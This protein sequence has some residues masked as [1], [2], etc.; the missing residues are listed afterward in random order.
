MGPDI[1][2]ERAQAVRAAFQA[3]VQDPAFVADAEKLNLAVTPASGEELAAII[4]DTFK[5]TPEEI[6]VARKYHH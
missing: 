6:A 1:P 3:M 2:A 5:A 4:G